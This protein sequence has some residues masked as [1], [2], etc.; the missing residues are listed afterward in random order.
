MYFHH[1]EGI[2]YC[3]TIIMFCLFYFP[4]FSFYCSKKP[5][6]FNV[7]FLGGVWKCET[8]PVPNM[9]VYF[10]WSLNC[11]CLNC[12]SLRLFN[13]FPKTNLRKNENFLLHIIKYHNDSAYLKLCFPTRDQPLNSKQLSDKYSHLR[14]QQDI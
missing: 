11:I 8:K 2:K 6:T 13:I 4:F 9:K 7:K 10:I 1:S 14:I 3:S 12:I 5:L